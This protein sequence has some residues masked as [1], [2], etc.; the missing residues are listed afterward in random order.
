MLFRSVTSGVMF[1]A[2][3]SNVAPAPPA[4]R[5]TQ[6][7]PPGTSIVSG[8]MLSPDGRS[9]AFIAK[10]M[11]SGTLSLWLRDLNS[12]APRLLNGTEGA[13][14]PFWS[15]DNS[16]LGFFSQ[17]QLRTVGLV[18]GTVRTLASV[19]PLP[20]GGTW[21]SGNTIIF[22]NRRSGLTAVLVDT[23]EQRP[24][25]T[26]D[27]DRGESGHRLPQFLPDGDH[28]IYTVPTP[29]QGKA[30]P[31]SAHSRVKHRV[32]SFRVRPKASSMPIPASCCT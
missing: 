22:G 3:A 27:R 12:T 29:R 6:E 5:F 7:A 14:R 28:F 8:G 30:G 32:V 21:G 9:L 25:T 19:G 24:V 23:G 10:D 18:D 1:M 2:R 4:I 13:S 16:A 11:S 15:P 31:T 26:L 17:G 20:L